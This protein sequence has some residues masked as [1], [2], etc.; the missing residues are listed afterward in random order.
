MLAIKVINILE[1]PDLISYKNDCSKKEA[2][3]IFLNE[4]CKN[5]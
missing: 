3:K 5:I 4:Q 1:K 2:K